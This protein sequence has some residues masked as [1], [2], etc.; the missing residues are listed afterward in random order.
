MGLKK[1]LSGKIVFIDTSPLIYFIEGHSE[2]QK[3]LEEV[4]KANNKGEIQLITTTLTLMEVLVQPYKNNRK[5][6]VE[7]YEQIITGSPNIEVIDID[8]DIARK[9]AEIR[10]IYNLKTPDAIQVSASILQ[11]ADIFLSN[12]AGFQKI[13]EIPVVLLGMLKSL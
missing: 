2:Y 6:L 10:A 3:E 4:F 7:K 13:K 9:A 8:L 11:K 12:D 5:D 1:T